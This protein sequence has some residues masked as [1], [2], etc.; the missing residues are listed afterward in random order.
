VTRMLQSL[1]PEFTY[2][3]RCVLLL[4]PFV[5]SSNFEEV[6]VNLL[7]INKFVLLKVERWVFRGSG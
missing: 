2:S 1:Y 6:V 5:L 3:Q 4:R 7:R